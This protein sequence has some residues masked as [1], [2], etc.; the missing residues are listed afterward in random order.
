MDAL[1]AIDK[2]LA[3]HVPELL[4]EGVLGT[5]LDI[6]IPD[7]TAHTPSRK[8]KGFRWE[9]SNQ[10]A[11]DTKRA[12][13]SFSQEAADIV[14]SAVSGAHHQ[15]ALRSECVC[16]LC[17][18][19]P[20]TFEAFCGILKSAS[21]SLSF[22]PTEFLSALRSKYVTLGGNELI[23]RRRLIATLG[24][25][26][27]EMANLVQL[28]DFW[29]DSCRRQLGD[30][31]RALFAEGMIEAPMLGQV[32]AYAVFDVWITAL[33]RSSS[34]VSPDVTGGVV[35][36]TQG[37][38]AESVL[39]DLTASVIAV[40]KNPSLPVAPEPEELDLWS[41]TNHLVASI[42]DRNVSR[43][44]ALHQ[45][46]RLCATHIE[47]SEGSDERDI[48]RALVLVT[49]GD[50]MLENEQAGPLTALVGCFIYWK[51]NGADS[52]DLL[53]NSLVNISERPKVSV[54]FTLLLK[55]F[56]LHIEHGQNGT[57]ADDTVQTRLNASLAQLDSRKSVLLLA[58][59]Y[60]SLMRNGGH[61]AYEEW[62]KD[63]FC[64]DSNALGKR[65]L[66]CLSKGL[67]LCGS[68]TPIPMLKAH[69]KAMRSSA[70]WREYMQ[71]A[72]GRLMELNETLRLPEVMLTPSSSKRLNVGNLLGQ[73]ERTGTIPEVLLQAIIFKG[74]LGLTE[75]GHS[76]FEIVDEN[77]RKRFIEEL[78][79]INKIPRN[80]LTAFLDKQPP[81][82][83]APDVL[84][85]HSSAAQNL[86]KDLQVLFSAVQASVK[87]LTRY[88]STL[89][90]AVINPQEQISQ[91]ARVADLVSRVSK[92]TTEFV[93]CVSTL[94]Q[95]ASG[96]G[97]PSG[98][99][100]V[101][102]QSWDIA[103]PN[104]SISQFEIKVVDCF[105]NAT[106]G[107]LHYAHPP[108]PPI[109]HDDGRP[110]PDAEDHRTVGTVQNAAISQSLGVLVRHRVIV[111]ALVGRLMSLLYPERQDEVG[112]SREMKVSLA[113]I[114]V[115]VGS[116]AA[117]D[118]EV[119]GK[120]RVNGGATVGQETS[121]KETM[122]VLQ[123]L[124]ARFLQN[125]KQCPHTTFVAVAVVCFAKG[126]DVS[127]FISL[128]EPS[129]PETDALADLTC[130]LIQKLIY[131]D[132][133]LGFSSSDEG[134]WQTSRT[135][136]RWVLEKL[137]DL[138]DTEYHIEQWVRW[139]MTGD[140]G[141]DSLSGGERMG[142]AFTMSVV[143]LPHKDLD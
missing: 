134:E 87:D 51:P 8:R 75:T 12:R 34:M 46:E 35:T 124:F 111:P 79:K 10:P 23:E 83:H 24:W 80:L 84:P 96:T 130:L 108:P 113:R 73:F 43:A 69:M 37:Y 76:S 47:S 57:H 119:V 16:S 15:M 55:L 74:L 95:E 77:L 6:S 49:D 104:G 98:R 67:M 139:E 56:L 1:A 33:V 118:F 60:I 30:D 93:Q 91:L 31:L 123:A 3:S 36:G 2:H 70:K 82:E 103:F 14:C 102:R 40:T 41:H 120:R 122:P 97:A 140:G 71:Y 22:N 32:E 29:H 85:S 117:E 131:L 26:S 72:K 112:M 135:M 54:N 39:N 4:C 90:S 45:M 59:K 28:D 99:L 53:T 42:T 133:R 137:P 11:T 121:G 7:N 106:H 65:E 141:N 142:E 92:T 109:S 44:F 138:A 110:P 100:W 127:A 66:H 21:D 64:D 89:P 13:R 136:L 81:S 116:R 132:C 63:T 115:E 61:L 38:V 27:R 126:L 125:G 68:E 105:L 101:D 5:V 129:L 94:R 114:L 86:P 17:W 50:G 9:V 107:I 143:F 62:F 52:A 25:L 88:A 20:P 19:D 78:R 128:Q 18:Q 58:M 48:M